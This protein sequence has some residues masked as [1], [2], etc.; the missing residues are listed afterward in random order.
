M[1]ITVLTLY[2]TICLEENGGFV[3]SNQYKLKTVSEKHTKR[4]NYP[5]NTQ[6]SIPIHLSETDTTIHDF[7]DSICTLSYFR[8]H[9]S[10]L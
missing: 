8:Y 7:G 4:I 6:H 3:L 1:E 10:S 2:M 5:Q 9:T